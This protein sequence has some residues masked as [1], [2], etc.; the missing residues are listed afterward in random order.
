MPK[1]S[2][3]AQAPLLRW[4]VLWLCLLTPLAALAETATGVGI[5]RI[6][7]TD[8]VS[9]KPTE[10]YVFYP[11]S[12]PLHGTTALGPYNVAATV[13]APAIPGA[14]PLVVISH[15]NGGS[16]L[17][18]HDLATYLASHGFVVATLNHLGDYFRDTS[19]V[20][21]VEVLAGRPV[22]VKATITL[23]LTDP[24]WKALVD[25]S[26]IG[27]AGFSAG[28]YTSLMVAGATP[29]FD[30]FIDFCNRYPDN[31]DVCG[32][33]ADFEATAAR[34]GKTMEQMLDDMQGE[35]GRYGDTADPRVKAAFAMAPLS[36]IFDEH[37]FDRVHI[38]VY[39]YYGQNDHVLPPEANA[40]HI[41]PLISSLAGVKEIPK[42]DHWVFLPP[43][44]P[45]LAKEI[46]A[47]C[48]DPQGVDRAKAH[49][50]INADALVFFRKTLDVH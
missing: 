48:R 4:L 50:Q 20:G 12:Q 18:H 19:G 10:G 2:R 22:Q 6:A 23:L 45:E 33:R 49:A 30:R 21:H 15:G 40:K 8:P 27:V 25:P 39:L 1:A 41:Q 17:G 11:S 31:H 7:I 36:L 37:G 46:P 42:A 14:K 44:S 43:C 28:G 24:H 5:T 29:R 16:D 9:G 3:R 32:H 34:Q 47:M 26:R 38:P 13:D 35:M